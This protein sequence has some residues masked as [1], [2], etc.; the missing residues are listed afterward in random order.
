MSKLSG[1]GIIA[2]AKPTIRNR[3]MKRLTTIGLYATLAGVFLAYLHTAVLVGAKDAHP[4]VL[5]FPFTG[6]YSLHQR[7]QNK[8]SLRVMT[9]NVA[10][11]RKDGLHQIFQSGS[12]I[13][14]NLKDVAA[15][16]R[17]IEPDIVALQ[18]ADGPSIWS[19]NLN[20]VQR[21]AED[22]SFQY[23]VLGEHA[24]APWLTNGTA[25]L[26]NLPLD[27]P[28]SVT[29][30]PTPPSSPKGFILATVEWPGDS[31]IAVDIV[32][33][34]LD[35]SRP[36][37]RD[38]QVDEIVQTLSQRENPLIVMGDFNCDWFTPDSAL[39]KLARELH[40]KAYEPESPDHV[41]YPPRDSRYDW[42]MISHEMEF[43]SYQVVSNLILDHLAVVSEITFQ[44]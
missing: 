34:H 6:A 39:R 3:W 38:E 18:E 27:A 35:W 7:G 44:E 1:T 11:G 41:T 33:V 9:L 15:A 23:A 16:L 24:Q 10:H 13:E 17:Q 8:F 37:V 42:I 29:F 14:A 40:L 19:G 12:T 28:L 43:K 21:L 26:S 32:S 36:S 20:H 25:I 4:E 5:V 2:K 31:R 22:S 30:S